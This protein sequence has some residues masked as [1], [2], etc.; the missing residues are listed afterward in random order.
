MK[1]KKKKGGK[2]RPPPPVVRPFPHLT[3]SSKRPK[4]PSFIFLFSLCDSPSYLPTLPYLLYLIYLTVP[5]THNII[6]NNKSTI[7]REF[8][9]IGSVTELILRPSRISNPPNPYP[10][11]PPLPHPSSSS[12][13]LPQSSPSSQPPLRSKENPH[14]YFRHKYLHVP[15]RKKKGGG[16]EGVLDKERAG[17][18]FGCA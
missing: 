6:T 2:T 14:S 9:L 1:K 10:P 3:A 18:F 11:L 15:D 12:S 7:T 13:P 16:G 5:H 8:L 4:H 17:F